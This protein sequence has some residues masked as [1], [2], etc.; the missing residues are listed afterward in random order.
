MFCKEDSG[1]QPQLITPENEE[2]DETNYSSPPKFTFFDDPDVSLGPCGPWVPPGPP[3]P[4]GHSP[5]WPPAPS[6][7]GEREKG[8]TGNLPRERLPLRPSPPNPQ[9]IPILMSDGGDDQSPQ[10]ERQRQQSR[11]RERVYP[12]VPVLQEPQIQPVLTPESDDE[13]SDEDFTIV[14]SSPPLA[15]QENR[16]RRSEGSRSRERVYPRSSSR[17]S[18]QQQPV[19]PPPPRIQQNQTAQSDDEN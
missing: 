12:H 19:V 10:G 11:S 14:S 16:S 3:G 1:R 7:A 4:P 18:Q 15:E 13:I 17:A 9:L 2:G 8:R 6:R 5:G